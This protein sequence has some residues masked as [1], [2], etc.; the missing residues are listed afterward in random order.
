MVQNLVKTNECRNITFQMLI[1]TLYAKL[2]EVGYIG[3]YGLDRYI[4]L[5]SIKGN[6]KWNPL[7]P[8][9]K[10]F[11][12]QG[13]KACFNDKF[14]FDV[15]ADLRY[16]S[17][18]FLKIVIKELNGGISYPRL[19][20]IT[21][22]IGGFSTIQIKQLLLDTGN[23]DFYVANTSGY[24]TNREK[25][26]NLDEVKK[27]VKAIIDCGHK[28]NGES[29]HGLYQVIE[30]ISEGISNINDVTPYLDLYLSLRDIK[31][32]SIMVRASLLGNIVKYG[33]ND[34]KLLDKIKAVLNKE[35]SKRIWS[36]FRTRVLKDIHEVKSIY[37]Y[38]TRTHKAEF[39]KGHKQSLL[40]F[41]Q[42]VEGKP[43][44]KSSY[45][46]HS[47]TNTLK[48]SMDIDKAT[49]KIT[50]KEDKITETEGK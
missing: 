29:H 46:R 34:P 5:I 49:G 27:V 35:K 2:A 23:L 42:F 10:V 7:I 30:D 6:I 32:Y 19:K 36:E 38:K 18:E 26:K 12:H 15:V 28:L 13:K 1:L 24:Y 9:L 39:K 40:Q 43:A 16:S 50:W 8:C 41:V 31:G 48:E 11:K 21:G 20:E 4:N 47:T 44:V 22:S 3:Y 37:D 17:G 33:E 14:N 45:W 25:F